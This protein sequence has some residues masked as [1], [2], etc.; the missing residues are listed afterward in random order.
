VIECEHLCMMMRG[1]E[2]Q[3]SKTITS[4]LRGSFKR[5]RDDARR[6]PASR[7]RAGRA[8]VT[9][10]RERRARRTHRAGHG[11]VARDRR[12][13]GARAGLG[14]GARGARGA[15]RG[16]ARADG[17]G[18]PAR[19]ARAPGRS[20]ARRRRV[21]ARGLGARP[22]R[23]GPGHRGARGR[24]PFRSARWRTAAMPSSTRRSR[25]TPPPRSGSRARC[26]RHARARHR[27]HR[28]HRLGGGPARVPLERRLRGDQARRARRPRDAARRDAWERGARDP[29]LA[30]A[31]DTP[32]WDPYEPDASPHL[33]S[34]AE[35]LSAEDVAD[36]VLWAVTRARHV[37]IEELRLS[38]S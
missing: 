29:G 4:A 18:A 38:R 36:A 33:P 8:P 31:T 13:H 19:R 23:R 26:S 17:G 22:A 37:D 27:T 32:I 14:R 30:A 25:S 24:A 12:R 28:D 11:R 21:R 7:L 20:H 10:A 35:M 15:P 9:R 1:V 6:V 5:R 2:K 34:R 3:N 16:G